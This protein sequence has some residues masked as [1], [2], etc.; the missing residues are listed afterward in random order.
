M[1]DRTHR[2]QS[3]S[4]D[5]AY[6]KP[7][8]AAGIFPS[9]GKKDPTTATPKTAFEEDDL[10]WIA[11]DE[12]MLDAACLDAEPVTNGRRDRMIVLDD[13][14]ITPSP[15]PT[16][17]PCPT[18]RSRI[19]A[20]TPRTDWGAVLD[21]VLNFMGFVSYVILAVLLMGVFNSSDDRDRNRW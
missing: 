13:G 12:L 9:H 19:K 16:P 11:S 5:I 18:R 21:G 7:K 2:P 3:G 14:L 1:P 20:K 8:S 6:E 15:L 4:P 17:P 10:A